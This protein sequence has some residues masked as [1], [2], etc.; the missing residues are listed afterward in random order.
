MKITLL[1]TSH[2]DPTPTRFQSSTLIEVG[3]RR[4]LIDAGEPVDALLIRRGLK[5]S[6]LSAVFITHVHIDH[7]GGLPVILEQARKFRWQFPN[8]RLTVCLPDE[9]AVAPLRAWCAA[10]RIHDIGSCGEET[11]NAY[12]PGIIYDD[13]ALRV[14]AYR[15]RHFPP[16][17]EQ[18]SYSLLVEADGKRVLFTGDLSTTYADFPIE[19]VGERCDL[20]ISELVH[21]PLENGVE[22]LR[23]LPIRQVIYQHLDDCWDTPEGREKFAA[24]I[25]KLPFPAGIGR[26]GETVLSD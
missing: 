22:M 14:T 17:G 13:G 25:A 20:L 18:R 24:A 8:N 19:A 5:A 4:Y 23:N 16:T 11:V 26:D 15:N 10:N 2:G 9:K 12:A 21:Y 3:E 1:G 6:Q 7:T